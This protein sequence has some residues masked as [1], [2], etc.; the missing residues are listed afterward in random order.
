VRA[1]GLPFTILRPPAVYGPAD[2]QFLRLFRLARLRVLP[3]LGDGTQALSLVHVHDLADGAVAAAESPVCAQGTYH[4]THPEIVS[5]R[6]LM[7]A[8]GEAMGRRVRVVPMPAALVRQVLRVSGAWSRLGG[9]PTLLSPDKAPELL[10]AAWTC[11]ADG[12]TRDARWTAA[13]TLR[14]GLAE[15]ALWYRSAGWL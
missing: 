3:L 12:L 13:L 6:A 2:R 7:A 9:K 14:E 8:V 5:Q 10:A 1:S 15:T 11:H 4:I